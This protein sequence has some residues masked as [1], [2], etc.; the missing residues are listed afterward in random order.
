MKIYV[1]C[2]AVGLAL[3]AAAP[4]A[5]AQTVVTRQIVDQPVTVRTTTTT[6]TVRPIA[7]HRVATTTRIVVHERVIPTER[8]VITTAPA[9]Y[10][11]PLYDT[12]APPPAPVIDAPYDSRPLYNTVTE[13][14]AI[15][16]VPDLAPVAGVAPAPQYR[17]VYE[18]DRILVIDPA[19]NIAVQALPR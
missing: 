11:E 13:T 10:P 3:A 19:T 14:P 5:D 7:H 1:S 2:A 15:A 12:V 9:A 16:P 18:S 6:R 17:Y 4:A 8:T